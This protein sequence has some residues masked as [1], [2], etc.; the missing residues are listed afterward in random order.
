MASFA[1]EDR[2]SLR[3]F[4]EQEIPDGRQALEGS[5]ANLERVAAYCE[6]NYAQNQDKRAAF[7]ETKR[8]TIQ[9]LA[10]VA[11][12]VNQLSASLLQTLDLQTD[13]IDVLSGEVSKM[14]Q[15][16]NMQK[17]KIARREIGVLASTK[18]TQKQA[19]IITPPVQERTERYKRAPIDYSV[20]D[21]IGNGVKKPPTPQPQSV[22]NRTLSTVSGSGGTIY[23]T[24]TP[25]DQMRQTATL[26]RSSM[27]SND[28]YRIPQMP[29]IPN[30]NDSRFSSVSTVPVGGQHNMQQTVYRQSQMSQQQQPIYSYS[31]SDH[32]GS[33]RLSNGS[34]TDGMPMPPPPASSHMPI[35]SPEDDMPPP[36]ASV[37]TIYESNN[38]AP[39]NYIE[40]AV[41]LYD[42]EAEKEDELTLRENCIVYVVRKN[43]DGW[44]EGVLD[45]VTGLFPGN[46]VQPL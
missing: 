2:L 43:D 7:E 15:V 36:P 32:Y 17:E 21:H 25:V 5:C 9:S 14:N 33:Y 27:R 29:Q 30:L 6:A 35:Y 45:G 42:Y 44:Y 34:S 20:L 10:S 18:C 26:S 12:L 37:E 39:M 3:K 16:V 19:K 8:F 41:A 28:H 22:I 31:R 38:Y 4:L 1:E 11:Y 24:S 40:K 13:K 23:Q 46:Y